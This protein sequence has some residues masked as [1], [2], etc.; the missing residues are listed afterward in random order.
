MDHLRRVPATIRATSL[1]ALGTL[2][3]HQLRYLLAY[4]SDAGEALAHQ[5]HGYLTQVAPVLAGLSVA[6]IAATLIVAALRR[7]PPAADGSVPIFAATMLFAAGLLAIFSTQELA[8]GVLAP[9][10]PGGLDAV[11][12][13]GGWI[14]APLA[15]AI[16]AL[17]ALLTR[18]LEG[19]ER[20]LTGMLAPRPRQRF[21]SPPRVAGQP[22]SCERAPLAA[23]TLGFGLAR[24]PPPLPLLNG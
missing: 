7:R 11:L 6:A 1:L 16:G 23:L 12:A 17:V 14:A 22:A 19:A 5:G 15:L 2:G 18:G 24:R 20:L 3:V 10:H 8:E 4:G 9:G 13:N 21:R